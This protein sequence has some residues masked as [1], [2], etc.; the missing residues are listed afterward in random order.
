MLRKSFLTVLSL[1]LIALASTSADAANAIV[2]PTSGFYTG[3]GVPIGPDNHLGANMG[4]DFTATTALTVT[5]LGV[6]DTNILNA[7]Q[8]INLVDLSAPGTVLASVTLSASQAS[9]ATVGYNY[10]GIAGVGLLAGHSYSIYSTFSGANG[11]L[12]TVYSGNSLS[13]TSP[14]ATAP[15]AG[16]TFTG[17]AV[18]GSGPPTDAVLL[19]ST[20]FQFTPAVPEPASIAMLGLGLAGAAFATRRKMAK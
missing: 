20:D 9:A 6:Y 19:L 7:G 11:Q 3:T 12:I 2:T 17:R 14:L 1:G 8:V 4:F 15:V 16:G 18:Y 10:F 5:S 13:L